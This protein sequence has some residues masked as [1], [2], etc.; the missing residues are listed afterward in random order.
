MEFFIIGLIS[1]FSIAVAILLVVAVIGGGITTKY[2]L[3]RQERIRNE[4]E[5]EERKNNGSK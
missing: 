5:W 2:E 1:G 3:D 4:I